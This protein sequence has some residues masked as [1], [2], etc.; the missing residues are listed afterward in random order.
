MISGKDQYVYRLMKAKCSCGS[1]DFAQYLNLKMDH[2]V[3]FN[4]KEYPL[5]NANDHKS[6][7]N[8][9]TFGRCKSLCNPGGMLGCALLG[10]VVG[11]IG[12]ATIGCVCEPLTPFPWVQ[13]DENYYID[14]APALTVNSVLHC[15]YG[16]EITITLEAEEKAEESSEKTTDDKQ[17]KEDKKQQLPSEVQEKIDSFCDD[18]PSSDQPPRG[19][20]EL[21]KGEATITA[22]G[23]TNNETPEMFK[24]YNE[25]IIDIQ[26][27]I[28]SHGGGGGKF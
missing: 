12:K 24:R 17:D 21:A 14:G 15:A 4:D 2:G 28:E 19:S 27:H 13:V 16:G 10:P 26:I 18:S 3:I 1:E 7:E 23:S 6:G 25:D 11:L 8:I 5:M 20:L 22:P 9:Y